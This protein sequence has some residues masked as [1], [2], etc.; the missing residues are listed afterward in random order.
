MM[1]RISYGG[2]LLTKGNSMLDLFVR[3]LLTKRLFIFLRKV[4]CGPRFL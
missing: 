3:L 2:L 4:S 1:G